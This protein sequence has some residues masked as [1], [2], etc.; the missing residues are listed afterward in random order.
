MQALGEVIAPNPSLLPATWLPGAAKSPP[1]GPGPGA[2]QVHKLTLPPPLHRWEPARSPR[3]HWPGAPGWRPPPRASILPER[4]PAGCDW[5]IQTHLQRNAC[6][7]VPVGVQFKSAAPGARGRAGAGSEDDSCAGAS[8]RAAVGFFKKGVR[9]G[10]G[11][12]AE[13]P[14]SGSSAPLLG[15][16]DAKPPCPSPAAA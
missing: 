4:A 11:G 10:G 14:P 2:P 8:P 15:C 9:G 16:S 12:L 3:P 7:R 6:L 1:A 13:V 5:L